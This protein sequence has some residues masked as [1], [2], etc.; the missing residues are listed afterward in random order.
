MNQ[1]D[2]L[3][4]LN[5]HKSALDEFS[6]RSIALFGSFAR[7]EARRNSD[8]DLLVEFDQPVGLFEFARLKLYL[9]KKLGR[10]VDLVTTEA[11]RKEMRDDILREALHVT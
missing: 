9:E 10:E 5:K 2:I 11:L 6:V 3:T 1:K 7:G 4:I 8:I